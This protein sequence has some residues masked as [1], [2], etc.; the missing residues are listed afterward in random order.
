MAEERVT[1]IPEKDRIPE[2]EEQVQHYMRITEDLPRNEKVYKR[3]TIPK[4]ENKFDQIA[5]EREEIRRIKKGHDGMSGKMYLYFHYCWI[6]NLKGGRI[7][8]EFR[9]AD[10]KFFDEID[11]AKRE[12]SGNVII[13][14]RRAGASWKIALDVLHDTMFRPFTSVGMNSKSDRDSIELFKKVKFLYDNLPLFLRATSRAGN[15]KMSMD[16]SYYIKDEKGNRVKRGTQSEI[17]VVP[18]TDSAYEGMMLNK[19]VCDEAGKIE[20]LP[21]MWSFT[22]DCLMQ[23]T[24]RVGQP[25]I[26]GTVGEVGKEGAGLKDMWDN[27]EVY[28]L[29]KFFIGG[30]MG[31]YVDALGNDMR[32]DAIRWIVYERYKRRNLRPK[33]QNDFMQKYPLTWE[34]AFS[35]ANTGGIGNPIKINKQISSLKGNPPKKANGK[36]V[37]SHDGSPMFKA[38]LM[39]D[40]IIWEHPQPGIR[41]YIAG[42]D[43]ADHDDVDKDASLMSTFIY[44]LPDGQE[45]PRIVAEYTARPQK[46]S[47][48]YDQVLMLL[49][50]YNDAKILIEN[51]RYRIISYFDENGYKH[52]LQPTPQGIARFMSTRAN[53]I[54]VRM[55]EAVKDYMVSLIEDYIEDYCEIIPSV[56]LLDEFIVFG[57]RNTDR[58]FAFGMC[59]IFAQEL[60]K[61]KIARMSDKKSDVPRFKYVR[62]A[63]GTIRRV[64]ADEK[65]GP[66]RIDTRPRVGG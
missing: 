33:L 9:V 40:V 10:A 53:T 48:Y 30:W 45:P 52:L 24:E 2:L 15:T 13:K 6:K 51:N 63:N 20:N 22:E 8:P 16:F 4:F 25:V 50:Y 66:V 5:W 41:K 27:A 43:P 56:E 61:Q 54:G 17:I 46:A 29:R 44:A 21:Q 32:E 36:M 1:V 55:T 58:V 39:G 59:L 12:Q 28:N 3:L 37:T 60:A 62:Q 35:L 38:Q 23:E 26:F 18:P 34:E 65:A 7:K 49:Q 14:R 57:A 64:S 19:W 47:D 11:I 42:N 31:T